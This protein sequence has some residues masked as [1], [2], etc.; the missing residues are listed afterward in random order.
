MARLYKPTNGQIIIDDYDIQKVE[1]Y[2]FR[3]QI[4]FVSQDPYLVSGSIIE[5]IS[6]ANPEASKEDIIR[7]SKDHVLMNSL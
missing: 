5:N 6:I 2:S 1:L 7:V 3:K 4:G